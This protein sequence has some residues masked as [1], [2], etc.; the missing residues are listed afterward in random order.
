MANFSKSS[1]TLV[2]QI[3][4][5]GKW[6]MNDGSALQNPSNSYAMDRPLNNL[7]IDSMMEK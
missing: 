5:E 4:V 1:N 6:E 3:G 7:E 2:S